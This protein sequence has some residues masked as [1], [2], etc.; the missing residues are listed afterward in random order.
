MASSELHSSAAPALLA[1]GVHKTFR[2]TAA[3][4]G[5]SFEVRE[6]A[7]FA[8]LG[9]NGAGK[10]TMMKIVNGRCLR[11]TAP[12][13]RVEVFGLDPARDELAVKNLCGVAPQEENFDEELNVRQNLDVYAR[14]YGL[15]RKFVA[16]RIAE[17]LEFM[18]LSEKRES[19]FRELS[20]GM[21]RR[22]LIARALLNEPRLL[23]LDEPTTGLDPQVRHVIWNK[24]RSLK[25]EGTTILLTT[26]YMEEAFQIADRVLIM[27]EG[28]AILEGAP[29][30][31]LDE[32]MEKFVL[33]VPHPEFAARVSFEGS[34]V[35]RDGAGESALF[36][37]NERACLDRAA[38][39]LPPGECWLRQTN[40]EDVFLRF[41]GRKLQ[42]GQ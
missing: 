20:G 30:T 21:K 6:G 9:P 8:L 38:A 19:R 1:G 10:T 18:E 13:S 15:P 2:D 36:Y 27:H 25:R 3:L 26:H 16:S 40:L 23:I 24:V 32:H 17:L 22:L 7:C 35:R 5:L 12:A 14:Y 11:D 4:K 34:S 33:E 41:T 42:E 39:E 31:L 28:K 29:K 37:S